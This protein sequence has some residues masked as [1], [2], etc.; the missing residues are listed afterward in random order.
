MTAR[1][2]V[3]LPALGL[4]TPLGSPSADVA[5]ALFRGTHAGL[6][7]RHDLYT[8]RTVRVGEVAATLPPSPAA[9]APWESR[10]NR[11]MLAALEQIRPSIDAAL[12]RHGPARVG[13]VLGT[14]T[15]GVAEHAEARVH[16]AR[17]GDWPAGS[18]YRQ[19]EVG[20]LSDHAALALGVAGPAY[21]IATACSASAKVFASGRRLLEAGICDAVVVGGADTLCRMTVAG[22]SSLEALSRDICNPFS[23]NRDGINIG[24][25]A[26]AFLMTRDEA[27]VSL[28][29]SGECSDAHH[30]S[31][32]HP[33]GKGAHEAMRL[34][35]QDA[36]LAPEDVAYINL[37]GTGTPLN[38]SMEAKAIA[39]LFG[40]T[41]ACSSTKAMI[42]H[43]LGAA[44][45]CEAAFV[46]LTLHPAFNPEN[47]LPPHLWD[48]EAD[49]DMPAL[50]LAEA[51]A[52]FK[53][54]DGRMAMLSN[55]F[56]FGGNNVVLAFGRG[57][58]P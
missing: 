24:E 23:R 42:G 39:R 57:A 30:I 9:A 12:R 29:G 8:G 25:G 22:F 2:P 7:A 54:R 48:G 55:S 33:D 13:V 41:V 15:S 11:L 40:S 5:R 32:P 45:A 27:P 28:L 34:A 4:V 14:S 37:H 36:A 10:N 58:P 52:Q 47:R 6:V 56:A 49:P 38:D 26:A 51:G 35:L 50:R 17:T 21:S 19:W 1:R 16:R 31:A 44:G 53:A 18:D 46:W 43:A 20:S 3:G